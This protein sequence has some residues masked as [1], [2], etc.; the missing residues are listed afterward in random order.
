MQEWDL[1]ARATV[2]WV[3]VGIGLI[4]L[5]AQD[6]NRTTLGLTGMCFAIGLDIAFGVRLVDEVDPA[7]PGPWP[8]L[9]G[10]L[11]GALGTGC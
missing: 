9:H 6:R 5:A 11:D 10:L 8:R 3:S 4:I 1:V 2:G 7:D